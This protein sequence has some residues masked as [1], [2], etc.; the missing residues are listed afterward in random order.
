[1][2]PKLSNKEIYGVILNTQDYI[3][4]R[5]NRWVSRQGVVE[6]LQ[7][8]KSDGR[9]PDGLTQ[10]MVAAH[11]QFDDIELFLNGTATHSPDKL[12]EI[13]ARHERY[14]AAIEEGERA[15]AGSRRKEGNQEGTE[16]V[17]QRVVVHAG[18]GDGGQERH[19]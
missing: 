9:A 18:D 14:R 12:K 3:R 2:T 19:P 11:K 7:R 13:A 17:Q 16:Q 10:M 5:M 4:N 8:I 6:L 1:M 15:Y